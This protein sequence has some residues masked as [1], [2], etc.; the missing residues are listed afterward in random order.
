M[1]ILL[2]LL[3]LLAVAA[4]HASTPV[5]DWV[6]YVI[7]ELNAPQR[8]CDDEGADGKR[9]ICASYSRSFSA[10]KSDWDDLMRHVDLP[11]RVTSDDGWVMKGDGYRRTFSYSGDRT[12]DVWLGRNSGELRF[13]YLLSDE[14]SFGDELDAATNH[15]EAFVA[16][17]GGVSIPEFLP[18]SFE[19][20][21][22]PLKALEAG[23][24]TGIVTAELLVTSDGKVYSVKIQ[25]E[26]P[27]D[28]GFAEAATRSWKRNRYRPAQLDGRAVDALTH[29]TMLIQKD[30]PTKSKKSK[31][32]KK[33]RE[34]VE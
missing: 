3:S 2:I 34:D 28:L 32:K 15:G 24:L 9:Q 33:K 30:P 14:E 4:P 8:S 26:D 23:V 11:M 18:E 21:P 20:I 17:F 7:A 12:I 29:V 10:F 1:K 5:D 22:F 16:G 25:N 31:S 27:P 6:A 19:L 13:S